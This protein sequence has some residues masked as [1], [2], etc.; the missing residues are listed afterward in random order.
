[1]GFVEIS[2]SSQENG[3]LGFQAAY[4]DPIF[5]FIARCRPLVAEVNMTETKEEVR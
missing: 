2:L 1:M 5:W 4:Y 3:C